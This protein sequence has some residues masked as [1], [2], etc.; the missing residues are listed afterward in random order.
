MKVN[1]NKPLQD[2]SGKPLKDDQGQPSNIGKVLAEVLATQNKGDI[3]KLWDWAQALYHGKPI[4]LDR[5]DQDTL[6][7]FIEEHEQATILVKAQLLE[8]FKTPKQ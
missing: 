3:I 6:K 4:D 8:L 2:L 1:L 7:K 5:A